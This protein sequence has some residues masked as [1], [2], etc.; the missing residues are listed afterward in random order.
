MMKFV[1]EREEKKGES[2]RQIFLK[3]W[4][5]LLNFA[6]LYKRYKLEH[7]HPQVV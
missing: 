6:G 5:G 7:K 3:A 1:N 4:Q 2:V